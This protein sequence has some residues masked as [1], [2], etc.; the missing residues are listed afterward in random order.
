MERVRWMTADD[1]YAVV[2]AIEKLLHRAGI[3][4]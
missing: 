4:T 2:A 1:G 3:E